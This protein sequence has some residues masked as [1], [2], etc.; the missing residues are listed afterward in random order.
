MHCPPEK[1]GNFMLKL[2]EALKPYASKSPLEKVSSILA[3]QRLIPHLKQKHP[4]ASLFPFPGNNDVVYLMSPAECGEYI[5]IGNYLAIQ[6]WDPSR[7]V[8]IGGSSDVVE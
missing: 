5:R 6:V 8:H 3:P 4:E 1:E 7:T 2:V